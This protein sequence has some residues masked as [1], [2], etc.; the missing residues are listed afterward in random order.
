MRVKYKCLWL[1]IV[2]NV[3]NMRFCLCSGAIYGWW[4]LPE[5]VLRGERPPARFPA[6]G[7]CGMYGVLWRVFPRLKPWADGYGCRFAVGVC[8][9]ALLMVSRGWRMWYVWR[10]VA[11]VS[12]D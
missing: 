2:N 11:R 7:V 9:R 10:F 3:K 8:S 4:Y 1:I 5:P 12:H 6:A